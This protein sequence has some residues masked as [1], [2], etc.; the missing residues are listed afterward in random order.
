MELVFLCS[1]N[2]YV[3]TWAALAVACS[4]HVSLLLMSPMRT[5]WQIMNEEAHCMQDQLARAVGAARGSTGRREQHLRG[6]L[7]ADGHHEGGQEALSL[8]HTR[9]VVRC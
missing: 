5:L 8:S 6:Q 3:D 4:D 7:C 1:W 2:E 9:A